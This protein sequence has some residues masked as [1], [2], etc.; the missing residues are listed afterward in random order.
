MAFVF[1]GFFFLKKKYPFNT[2]GSVFKLTQWFFIIHII[3]AQSLL[4]WS[5]Q[6][7]VPEARHSVLPWVMTEQGLMGDLEGS[8]VAQ[9]PDFEPLYSQG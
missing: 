2:R 8:A 4:T 1:L 7:R 9:E 5:V 6:V 3:N